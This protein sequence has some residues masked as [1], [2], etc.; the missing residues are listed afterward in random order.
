M[1]AEIEEMRLP[2]GDITR[3]LTSLVRPIKPAL[4]YTWVHRQRLVPV[5]TNG[6]GQALFRVGDVLD[7]MGSASAVA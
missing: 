6:H 2:A 3:A 5:G 1:L 7:L 4:L